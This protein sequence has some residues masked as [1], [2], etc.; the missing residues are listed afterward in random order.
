MDRN[1]DAAIRGGRVAALAPDIPATAA[2]NMHASGKYVCPGLIDSHG[3]SYKGAVL[4][5]ILSAQ[6]Q[7]SCPAHTL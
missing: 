4:E 7:A 6:E 2:P 3:H 1:M 5:S